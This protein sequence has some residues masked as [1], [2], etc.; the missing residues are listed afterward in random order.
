MSTEEFLKLDFRYREPGG[1]TGHGFLFASSF[2]PSPGCLVYT[3]TLAVPAP[4]FQSTEP[5][6]LFPHSRWGLWCLSRHLELCK[7]P[8]WVLGERLPLPFTKL[9]VS[10]VL[11]TAP[12]SLS[13]LRAL[14]LHWNACVKATKDVSDGKSVACL[15]VLVPLFLLSSIQPSNHPFLGTL[16]S[17]DFQTICLVFLLP[18]GSLSVYIPGSFKSPG[19]L[20]QD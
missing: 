18:Y 9:T 16:A 10:T 7:S 15:S 2:P 11:P 19:P 20:P 5:I 4:D 14:S 1:S 17:R 8:Y 12:A 3:F 13:G 6:F